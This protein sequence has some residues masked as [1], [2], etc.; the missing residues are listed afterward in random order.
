MIVQHSAVFQAVI[1]T[2]CQLTVNRLFCREMVLI[3]HG[4]PNNISALRVS[5][6]L[7]IIVEMSDNNL[8]VGGGGGIRTGQ[9]LCSYLLTF[10]ILLTF[11]SFL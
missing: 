4:F 7:L 10:I 1:L 2:D 8:G 11:L 6:L 3:I 9:I 5:E